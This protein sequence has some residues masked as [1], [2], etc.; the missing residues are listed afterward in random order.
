LVYM[1]FIHIY[2]YIYIYIYYN[3]YHIIIYMYIIY[4]LVRCDVSYGLRLQYYATRAQARTIAPHRWTSLDMASL[5][6]GSGTDW[7][8][9]THLLERLGCSASPRVAYECEQNPQKQRYLQHV[10]KA[11]YRGSHVD[12]CIFVDATAMH[13]R[14]V[15]CAVHKKDCPVPMNAHGPLVLSA[16]PSCKDLSR[17]KSNRDRPGNKQYLGIST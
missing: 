1:I 14:T 16:G 13:H 15:K 4:T 17:Q 11:S 9:A 3:I 10:A 6:S 8:C 12:N 2:I 7:I 5:C